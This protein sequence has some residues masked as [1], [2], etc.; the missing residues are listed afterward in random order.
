MLDLNILN[1]FK[2]YVS[3]PPSDRAPPLVADI[4]A[5]KKVLIMP[6]LSVTGGYAL[7]E[8]DD[9]YYRDLVESYESFFLSELP[10]YRDAPNS[11]PPRQ[12]S[13]A[14]R[15]Y[16]SLP[17][18]EQQFFSMSHLS[19]LKINDILVSEKRASPEAKFDLFLE[20][21]DGVADFVPAF[22]V[23]IAKHCF[24]KPQNSSHAFFAR[25]KAIRNNFYK[26][27][28][29]QKRVDRILNG[30]R[31]VMYL[32]SAAAQDGKDLDGWIQDTWLLT[33]DAGLAALSQVFYFVPK[34]GERSQFATTTDDPTRRSNSYWRYVDK[35]SQ[36]LNAYRARNIQHRKNFAD[37]SHIQRMT[38]LSLSLSERLADEIL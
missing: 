12:N 18:I 22:E 26:G 17:K 32:R 4:E 9:A 14:S 30:A 7:G 16:H 24:D 13:P 37:E 6:G 11:I 15:Q 5:I 38:A 28:R 8:A 3:T 35:T 34:G 23:E 29:G 25:S 20:F 36:Q 33:C 19:L 1:R 10:R 27:G 21:M 31:D 2:D